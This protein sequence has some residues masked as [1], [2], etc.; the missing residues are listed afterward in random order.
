MSPTKALTLLALGCMLLTAMVA[1]AA[2]PADEKAPLRSA[3]EALREQSL[4]AHER[5]EL[6]ALEAFYHLRNHRPAWA[7][8]ERL[9]RLDQAFRSLADD[10]LDP[11][12][13]LASRSPYPGLPTDDP[14][15]HGQ[16]ICTEI[17][18]TRAF[19]R[20]L[21]DLRF[22]R[23]RPADVETI[24]RHREQPDA[25]SSEGRLR[26]LVAT[27][28]V[29]LDD[30]L[31]AFAAVRPSWPAYAGLRAAHA[32]ERKRPDADADTAVPSGPLLRPGMHDPRVPLLRQ[33]FGIAPESPDL[34]NVYDARL[35]TA[36][37]AF[38]QA[39]RLT[40]DGI[41]GP[42]TLAV[43]NLDRAARL[44]KFR[45][46]LERMRWLAGEHHRRFV[47]VDVAGAWIHYYRDG[48]AV[49]STRAQVGRPTRRTPLLVSE[50][51]HF[52][53]N[54]TWT[55]PPTILRNDK[56]PE[57]RADIGYLARNNIRVL[58]HEGNP[59][60]PEAIDW[61]RPGPILLRQDAGPDNALGRVAIR[62]PNP[63][64]V[65]LHD[66]PSQRLFE[67]DQRAFSSGCVRVQQADTLVDLLLADDGGDTLERAQRLRSGTRTANFSLNQPVAVLLTYLTVDIADDGTPIFRPDVYRLDENVLRALNA[68]PPAS[69]LHTRCVWLDG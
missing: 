41:I 46:N 21:S 1:G 51:T 68:A 38:Q 40:V 43:L 20:A 66:T 36:I 14:R 19:L 44:D 33:R 17:D 2:S 8:E 29:T 42:A 52:T 69:A 23:L 47:L 11:T 65:Y 54:P 25:L 4:T 30:P 50:I 24:W 31:A 15:H 53:F 62:F 39:N 18:A 34:A 32:A 35:V 57:I 13:Y 49:W 58:D 7:D 10:G 48:E 9:N 61:E 28:V 64:H 5:A 16:S 55:I 63:F 27:A 22:G 6:A 26:S 45:V 37:E 56:L 3:L 67:R 59:L 12:H 60:S